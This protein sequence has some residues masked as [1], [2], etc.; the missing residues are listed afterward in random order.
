[1]R[2]QMF[3]LLLLAG[4]V[5]AVDVVILRPLVTKCV[6]LFRYYDFMGIGTFLLYYNKH[7]G[8][9]VCRGI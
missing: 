4:N 7:I 8:V 1:M 6:C 3:D 2:L 5:V 9:R